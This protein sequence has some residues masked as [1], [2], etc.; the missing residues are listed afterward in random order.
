[1]RRTCPLVA[2]LTASSPARQAPLGQIGRR[3]R[4][5]GSTSRRRSAGTLMG[6]SR[7][8]GFGS[9]V[10]AARAGDGVPSSVETRRIS[11]ND[12]D[13]LYAVFICKDDP[14]KI[15]AN[16]TKREAIMGDDIVGLVLDHVPRRPPR[17]RVPDESAG[18]QMDG[19]VTEGQDDDFSYDTLWQSEGRLT[20]G[21]YVVL[22]K[23]PFKSL[24]FSNAPTQTWGI[25]VARMI[26]RA[27]EIRSGP[28]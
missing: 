24:R 12:E 20:G 16:M 18:I 3:S 9:R 19:V 14:S 2:F 26:P 28:T 4:F 8:R 7:H 27:N 15:R 6:R 23:I 10:R 5:R 22:M 1:M 25:A 17:V 11:R 13:H 21:R